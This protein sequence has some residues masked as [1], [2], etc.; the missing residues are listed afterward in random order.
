MLPNLKDP[1]IEFCLLRRCLALPKIMFNLRTV[2]TTN[3]LPMLQEFD[4]ITRE[5]LVR[6]LGSPLTDQQWNQAKLPVSMGGLELRAAEDHG[7]G[8]YATSFLSCQHLVQQL[9]H[10]PQQDVEQEAEEEQVVALSSDVFISGWQGRQDAALDVT[11]TNPLKD[12]TR[13]GAAATAG[14]GASQ[15]YERKMHTSADACWAQGII[16][17]PLATETFGGWHE[18]AEAQVRKLAE[19]LARHN[20]QEEGEAKSRLRGLLKQGNAAM[21][22]NR[23][24]TFPAAPID[25]RE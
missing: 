22:A 19:A 7:E 12:D 14:H 20:G 11:V 10:K 15:A 21:M 17:L 23:I 13:A 18:V 4:Q 16:F 1:H 2:D 25:G 5:A 3:F 9:L 24:P 8:A 6:I